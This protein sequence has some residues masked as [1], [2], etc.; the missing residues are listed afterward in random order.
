MIHAT[1]DVD[2]LFT[3]IILYYKAKSLCIYLF[4]CS[5]VCRP[6]FAPSSVLLTNRL[7][8]A[9]KIRID[10]C[11]NFLWSNKH[12]FNF[13]RFLI[14]K[15]R[16]FKERTEQFSVGLRIEKSKYRP[17]RPFLTLRH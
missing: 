10:Y 16:A 1:D 4:V 7:T 14:Q 11:V 13:L 12:T 15:L 8:Q 17:M 2:K 6:A 9:L 5:F 3:Y